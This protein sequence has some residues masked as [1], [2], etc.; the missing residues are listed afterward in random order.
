MTGEVVELEAALEAGVELELDDTELDAAELD[1]GEDDDSSLVGVG[2]VELEG[3]VVGAELDVVVERVEVVAALVEVVEGVV[4]TGVV[5]VET[6]VGEVY[7]I[8]I[9]VA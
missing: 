6:T 2:V 3:A 8:C 1:T 4:I 7:N 5:M 9:E